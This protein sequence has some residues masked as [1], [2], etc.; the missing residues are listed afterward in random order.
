M[1]KTIFSDVVAQLAC[2]LI[3]LSMIVI[4][5]SCRR[6][7]LDAEGGEGALCIH[8]SEY[9]YE[10]TKA[11]ENIPDTSEFLLKITGSGGETVYDGKYGDS[12]EKLLV[13]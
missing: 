11:T 6:V 5:V 10:Q 4:P 1:N 7:Q 9:S 3:Y 13:K 12:P 8:F 2:G